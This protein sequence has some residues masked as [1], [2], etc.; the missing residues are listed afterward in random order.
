MAH[1]TASK[2]VSRS[3]T[4]AAAVLL[5]ALPVAVRAQISAN[6]AALMQSLIGPRVDALTILGG[7]FGL[8]D[9][10]F[11]SSQGR[12]SAAAV[13]VDT[14]VTKFGGD[15]DIGSPK[16]LGDLSIGWQPLLQGNMGYLESR[17]RLPDRS[18]SVA[19][20]EFRTLAVEF[21]GGVRLWTTRRLSFAPTVMVLYG[22]SDD[23][24]R[25]AGP[26]AASNVA[27]LR[28]LGLVGWSVSTWS[29]RPA[30][31]VQYV[32]PLGR[33]LVT[34][35]SDTAGFFTH[36]FS[37]SNAHLRVGG[38]SGLVTN[39]IDLDIPLGVEL[40]GH[41]L[42]TGGYIGRTDLLGDLKQGL[43]VQHL[44]ELHGRLVLDFLNQLWGVQWIGLG[45]S[46]LWGTNL[47]GWTVG[48]DVEFHF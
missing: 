15:G 38:V 34:F 33:T 13:P 43:D 8:S 24:Y 10:E 40:Y 12:T 11:N 9:G 29:L 44:N 21:G 14:S 30:M 31:N 46:Y 35:S 7:D 1:P 6:Q 25:V 41:E 5:S 17:T 22:R 45:A 39:K 18:G 20:N 32:L 28:Q 4:L 26:S 23:D 27:Q 42:R 48:A 19:T 47:S 3:I 16:P 36:G 2:A 37:R